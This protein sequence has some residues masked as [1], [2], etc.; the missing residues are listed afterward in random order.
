MRFALRPLCLLPVLALIFTLGG[1]ATATRSS[2]PG[3]AL[4]DVRPIEATAFETRLRVTVRVT[5]PGDAPLTFSGSRHEL[6]I[7]GR[8]MGSALGAEPLTVPALSTATQETTLSLSNFTLLALARDLQR[9]PT[10]RYTISST[11]FIPGLLKRSVS[12]ENMGEIDLGA[13]AEG[14]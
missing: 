8:A 7:N 12:S 13:L 14:R 6:T 2:A 9:Q 4:V 11:W 3:V 5:N 10:T 1:C